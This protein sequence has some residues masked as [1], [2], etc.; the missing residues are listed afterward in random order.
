MNSQ[1]ALALL[2]SIDKT[3]KEIDSISGSSTLADSY[4]AKFLV[5]YICGIY[6]EAVESILID[7]T[8]RNTSREEIV[9]YTEETLDRYFR[10]PDFYKLVNLVGMFGGKEWKNELKKLK[11]GGI[12]LDSIVFNKNSLA[13]GQLVTTTLA[14]VKQFYMNSRPVIERIDFLVS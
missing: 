14:D 5:V 3:I 12:A 9:R 7:F 6:E 11:S 4:F 10:N 1:S 8:K 13:H 2:N